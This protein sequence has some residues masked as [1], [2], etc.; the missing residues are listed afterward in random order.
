MQSKVWIVGTTNQILN[1]K[2][3]IR[4]ELHDV[5]REM[6]RGLEK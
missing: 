6:V 5:K 2:S 3:T 4:F 1:F